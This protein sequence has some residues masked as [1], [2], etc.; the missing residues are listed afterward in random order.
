[1]LAIIQKI[2]NVDRCLICDCPRQLHISQATYEVV[3]VQVLLGK[4]LCQM[5]LEFFSKWDGIGAKE[6]YQLWHSTF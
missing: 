3:K 4:L 1:M 2:I 6:D 5:R